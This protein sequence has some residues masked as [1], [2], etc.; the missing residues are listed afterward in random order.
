MLSTSETDRTIPNTKEQITIRLNEK[1]T[2][3]P[4]GNEILGDRNVIKIEAKMILGRTT[5][6]QHTLNV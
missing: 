4:R 6:I 5:E 2:C 3:V 1:D